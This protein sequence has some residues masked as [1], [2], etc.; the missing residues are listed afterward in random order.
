ME[1]ERIKKI[2]RRLPFFNSEYNRRSVEAI[3]TVLGEQAFQ[4]SQLQELKEMVIRLDSQLS[5]LEES[6]QYLADVAARQAYMVSQLQQKCEKQ[7]KEISKMALSMRYISEM[8]ENAKP[9]ILQYVTAMRCGDAVGNYIQLIN[10]TLNRHGIKCCIYAEG[11]D[12]DINNE[13][14]KPASEMPVVNKQDILVIHVTGETRIM[15]VLDAFRGKIIIC[16]HNITPPHYFEPYDRKAYEF[17]QKGFNQ[18]KRVASKV[19]YCVADSSYNKECL[20]NMG[21]TGRIDIIPIALNFDEYNKNP[22]QK[23]MNLQTEECK[24]ILSVG[25]IAPNKKIEDILWSF[26]AY[27]EMYDKNARLFLVGK[28]QD[29]DLYYKKLRAIVKE[30]CIENVFFTGKVSIEELNAYYRIADAYLCLSEHEGFCVPLVEAMYFDVP[31]L[32]FSCT[33]VPDTLG[34]AGV[35]LQ[36]KN[37]EAV[38]GM[39]HTIF[40]QEEY[41]Y[42]VLEKQRM[43]LRYFRSKEI[44]ESFYR[45]M[46]RVISGNLE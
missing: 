3:K 7:E 23:V 28:Y 18:L 12:P 45:Y 13:M 32:A 24:T 27:K 40:S 17:V 11:I 16:Y 39:L 10:E 8:D 31:V 35:L 2:I 30:N 33:A 21:F 41:R 26:K 15:E 43:R 44:E 42:G 29:E 1:I 38:A 4:I 34:G 14:V 20:L 9:K 6:K 46:K 5:E 19:Q 22:D 36:D 37:Q 25:R